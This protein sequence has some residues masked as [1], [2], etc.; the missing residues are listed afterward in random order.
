[1]DPS[2]SPWS[3]SI[4]VRVPAFTDNE[5]G[6]DQ[7]GT[8]PYARTG[9]CSDLV[10]VDD[11][12]SCEVSVSIDGNGRLVSGAEDKVGNASESAKVRYYLRYRT[13]RPSD[14]SQW[15]LS[16][17][18]AVPLKRGAKTTVSV[19]GRSVAFHAQCGRRT[20]VLEV[21][22]NG[23]SPKAVS[24]RRVGKGPCSPLVLALPKG[25]T[26]LEIAYSRLG[27]QDAL[28]GYVI[29]T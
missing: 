14:H 25:R 6:F 29:L 2:L 10:P 11:T 3:A 17:N 27:G 16:A 15:R 19:K 4:K 9:A 12:G 20:G 26:S 28:M 21:R 7:S 5:S 8:W 13:L 23:G 22:I 1:M 24:L 18:G